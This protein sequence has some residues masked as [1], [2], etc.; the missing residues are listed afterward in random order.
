LFDSHSKH[1]NGACCPDGYSILL[2]FST[3]KALES[4]ISKYYLEETDVNIQ[5]EAQFIQIEKENENID[6]KNI[7][8]RFSEKKL[9]SSET[10]KAK[11][12]Q[13]NATESSKQKCRQCKATEKIEKEKSRKRNATNILKE[14]LRKRKKKVDPDNVNTVVAFK[15][16][17]K[18]GPYYICVVCNRNLYKKTVKLFAIQNYNMDVPDL[19]IHCLIIFR[20]QFSCS[21]IIRLLNF[22][23]FSIKKILTSTLMSDFRGS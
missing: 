10:Q 8:R 9:K 21:L 23:K 4:H 7:Y 13:R 18:E 17:I 12:R 2:R 22:H 3:R 11:C 6:L 1:S 20:I 5:F 16:T 19:F 14:N 15:N